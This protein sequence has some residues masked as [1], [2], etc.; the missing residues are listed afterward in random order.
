MAISLQEHIDKIRALSQEL[1]QIDTPVQ[2]ASSSALFFFSKRVFQ[3]GRS[4]T[5]GQFQYNSTKPLYI[6]P[7]KFFGKASNLNPPKGKNG[8]TQFKSGKNHVTTWVE[9]YKEA[10]GI[11]GRENNFVNWVGF[12]DLK[13]EIENAPLDRNSPALPS[14]DAKTR[15]VAF[16]DYVVKTVSGE[17][18]DKLEG[19]KSKYPNVFVFNQEEKRIYYKAFEFEVLKLINQRLGNA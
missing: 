3:D 16:N 2:L 7:K 8:D 4:A 6:N 10:R 18:S 11:V 9:S 5:G 17:N 14:R 13:S 1:S 15:K 12:G 19:L